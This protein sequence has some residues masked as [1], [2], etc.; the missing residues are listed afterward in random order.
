VG[1]KVANNMADLRLIIEVKDI[2]HLSRI[3]TRIENIP[4]VLEAQ[5]VKPG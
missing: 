4:N 1:V 3:L 5:R 2:T